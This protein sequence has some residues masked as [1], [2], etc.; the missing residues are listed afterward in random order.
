MLA[1]RQQ[2][3]T[4]I[5]LMVG[6]AILATLLAMGIPAFTGWIQDTQ[7]RTAA[8]SILNGLQTARAEAVRAIPWCVSP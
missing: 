2:G 1:R 7:V 4:L 3:V 6:I 5:E 8:E